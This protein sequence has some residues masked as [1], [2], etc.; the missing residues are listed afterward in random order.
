MLNTSDKTLTCE[1]GQCFYKTVHNET[2]SASIIQW[3]DVNS[4]S[5]YALNIL[6]T[7]L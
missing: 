4:G 2:I 3:M 5:I 7:A 1:K 6:M